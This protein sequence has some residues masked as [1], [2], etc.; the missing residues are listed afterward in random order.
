MRD[1]LAGRN[2]LQFGSAMTVEGIS[3]SSIWKLLRWLPGFV[4]RRI[5]TKE[6]LGDLV[7]VDVRPRYEYATVNLGEVSSFQIWLQLSNL[8][9]F[10]IELDRAELRFWCGGVV[11]KAC[12]LK[13]KKLTSGEVCGI[14]I[15]G[16]IS[17]GQANHIARH[18][19]NHGSA[20]EV[21]IEFNC[22]LHNFSKSTGH[23]A[24]VIP[25]FINQHTRTGI[26]TG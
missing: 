7:V 20:I 11:S 5:F 26:H 23:L 8:S 18:V 10:A 15:D 13:K 12:I 4:L 14:Y 22:S 25:R 16:S 17:D 6:R 9:P 24:G 21:D 1:A 2:L 3:I 19:H